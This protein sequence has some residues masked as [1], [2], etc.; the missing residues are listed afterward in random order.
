MTAGDSKMR[1]LLLL[2][3]TALQI[4]A[5]SAQTPTIATQCTPAGGFGERFGGAE[6][7]GRVRSTAGNRVTFDPVSPVAPYTT[8]DA[9][10]T[11]W[12]RAIFRVGAVAEY[13]DKA[14]A[15]AAYTAA[16]DAVAAL[17]WAR[18][19]DGET[20]EFSSDPSGKSGVKFSI[21]LFGAGVW[22]DCTD[23]AGEELAYKEALG[24]APALTQRPERPKLPI[25]PVLPVEAD[26]AVAA[27]RDA[28][29][30]DPTLQLEAVMNFADPLLKYAELL[31]EWKGQQLVKQGVWTEQRR[32]EFWLKFLDDPKF[33]ASFRKSMDGLTAMMATLMKMGD[34]EQRGDATG[35]CRAA[36]QIVGHMVAIVKTVEVQW[37]VVHEAYALEAAR[38]G[39]TLE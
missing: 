20:V 32:T 26:C 34:A 2:A 30:A 10:V 37:T 12:G 39:V 14:T 19:T 17:G 29:R 21:S 4:G 35:Q 38:L 3:A 25:F 18:T 1:W 36:V 5:A 22:L 9:G 8:Y 11:Q 31:S 6:F 24:P 7:A 15:R 33:A 23:R 27:K 28:I 16:I 13:A